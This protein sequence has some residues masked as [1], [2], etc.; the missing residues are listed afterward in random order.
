MALRLELRVLRLLP[1]IKYKI[2]YQYRK[3]YKIIPAINPPQRYN[4]KLA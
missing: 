2:Y 4:P 1:K 3:A